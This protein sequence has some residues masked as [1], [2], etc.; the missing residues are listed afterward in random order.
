MLRIDDA[1]KGGVPTSLSSLQVPRNRYLGFANFVLSTPVLGLYSI[2]PL[3]CSYEAALD[4]WLGNFWSALR[5]IVP[6][7]P[8]AS[9]PSETDVPVLDPPKFKVIYISRPQ[10]TTRCKRDVRPDRHFGQDLDSVKGGSA[11]HSDTA[12]SLQ[13]GPGTNGG[14]EGLGARSVS[15]AAASSAHDRN[16]GLE[17]LA[18]RTRETAGAS[19]GA[20]DREAGFTGLGTPVTAASAG[21]DELEENLR[22]IA[23]L[24]AATEA[25]SGVLPLEHRGG[26]GESRLG[27]DQAN[28]YLA[29]M[30][31]IPF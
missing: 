11:R 10:R 1:E 14:L 5:Q 30:V 20:N 19:A 7:P 4:P 23:V 18:E 31:S 3:C 25:S 22:A 17:G 8:G 6:L 13:L 2:F 9:E 21:G 28:P 15:A 29:T 26:G 24:D 27:Y 16:G 12:V